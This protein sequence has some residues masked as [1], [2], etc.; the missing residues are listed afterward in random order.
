VALALVLATAFV[1][2]PSAGRA[3]ARA[4]SGPAPTEATAPPA[5]AP[6]TTVP[7]NCPVVA[8]G[9]ASVDITGDGCPDDVS[10][11][12]GVVTAGTARWAVGEPGD[13]LLVADWDCDGVAT[14]AVVR[15]ASGEVFVF[16]DWS[17]AAA[18]LVATAVPD[19]SGAIAGEA[20]DD[21]AD[22]CPALVVDTADGPVEVSP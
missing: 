4:A 7:Q 16:G 18:D 10:I 17:D 11:E 8:S 13:Q 15:P 14:V 19:V 12:D 1:V 21:D 3:P 5:V 6:P 9:D 22:G 20:V 2:R